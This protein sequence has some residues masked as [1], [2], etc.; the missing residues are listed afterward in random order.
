MTAEHR[1]AGSGVTVAV[2]CPCGLYGQNYT[3]RSPQ[4]MTPPRTTWR[5]VHV[6]RQR[7]GSG[8]PV[9]Q[10]RGQRRD[11]YRQPLVG[12]R[13][14]LATGTFASE[15][16]ADGRRWC[17]Q[18]G[19]DRGEHAVRGLLLRPEATTPTI[20]TSST[21]HDRSIDLQPLTD[22]LQGGPRDRHRGNGVFN[23]GGPGFRPRPTR[24][25]LWR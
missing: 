21:R 4:E 12:Q 1:E 8:R 11:A 14:L 6:E 18:P 24:H 2:N 5:Q 19:A 16:P 17:Y 23:V 20:L 13:S 7:L 10:G 25:R 22:P 3:P 15:S 9:L